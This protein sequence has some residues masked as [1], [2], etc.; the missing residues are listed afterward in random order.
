MK[1]ATTHVS[2]NEALIFERSQP[3][4]IGYRL[5]ALDVEETP[6]DE[7]L[8]AELRRDDDL[9]GFPEVSEPD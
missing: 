4:R 2:Q 8:P 9:E 3:G 1:K 6:L 7:I 5:P